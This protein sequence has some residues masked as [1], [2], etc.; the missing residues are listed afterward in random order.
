[1][2]GTLR[3]VVLQVSL[4]HE[5]NLNM[6]LKLLAIA[7]LALTLCS[8][9]SGRAL[10]AVRKNFPNCD[11]A[12][13][14]GEKKVYVIRTPDNEVWIAESNGAGGV[15]NSVVHKTL[16]IPSK[17]KDYTSPNAAETP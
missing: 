14:P 9:D 6:K 4:T 7:C 15:D 8:C 13:I 5:N 12:T 3:N 17:T 10:N 2:N 1:M 11:V 16:L